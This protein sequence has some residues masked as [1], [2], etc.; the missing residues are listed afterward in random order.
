MIVAG[1]D[2]G[3]R[4]VKVVIMS[5]DRILSQC[6]DDIGTSSLE[7]SVKL[8]EKALK[9]AWLTLKEE[10]LGFFPRREPF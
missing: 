5:D 6:I 7:S 8:T 9:E 3:S 1:I 2:T 10:Q 4:T